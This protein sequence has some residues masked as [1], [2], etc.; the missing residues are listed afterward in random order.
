LP[1]L[2]RC[3]RHRYVNPRLLIGLRCLSRF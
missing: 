3:L 2:D 1:A